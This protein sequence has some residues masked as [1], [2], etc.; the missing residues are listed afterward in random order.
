LS[1]HTEV[2]DG[3]IHVHNLTPCLHDTQWAKV[4]T[5]S[6]TLENAILHRN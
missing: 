6:I 1:Q 5:Y 4:I 2:V 3:N